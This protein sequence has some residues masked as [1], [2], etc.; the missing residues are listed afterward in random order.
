MAEQYNIRHLAGF[1]GL[2]SIG[3]GLAEAA[4]PGAVERLVGLSDLKRSLVRVYGLRELAAGIGILSRPRSPGWLWGRVAGD[5]VDL[6]SLGSVV[7]SEKIDKKKITMAVMAVLGITA[8]DI[9]SAYRMS[10]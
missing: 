4:A 3:L 5:V 2:F 7:N 8:L 1:L 9:Y 10:R 6:A